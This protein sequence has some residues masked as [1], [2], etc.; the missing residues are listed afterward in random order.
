MIIGII[1][2]CTDVAASSE[3]RD[4]GLAL[5]AVWEPE[6]KRA[7]DGLLLDLAPIVTLL[8]GRHGRA[9]SCKATVQ[10]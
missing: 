2:V 8:I 10:W 6:E 1:L 4:L 3:Q 9:T 5:I 7:G